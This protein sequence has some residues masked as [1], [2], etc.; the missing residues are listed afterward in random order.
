MA[1]GGA[2]QVRVIGCEAA[3]NHVAQLRTEGHCHVLHTECKL[4]E[5]TAPAIVNRGGEIG[6]E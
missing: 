4:D 5:A 1:R 3:G 6:Q 2:S